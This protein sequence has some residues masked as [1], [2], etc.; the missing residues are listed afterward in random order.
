MA[1]SERLVE[2]L[3]AALHKLFAEHRDSYFIGEDLND[4]YGG[5]FKVGKGLSTKYP[6]RVLTTPLSENG[7]L[8]VAGGLAL[9]GNKVIVEMMFGDFTFLAFDQLCNFAAKSVTMYGTRRPLQ[10]IVRCPVGGRRGYGPTHSQ[11]IQKH[12]IGVPNLALYELT[13]F[14]DSADV[15]LKMLA[16][17]E[18]CVYFEDKTLYG[19]RRWVDGT[20]DVFEFGFDGERDE[21]GTAVPRGAAAGADC[22]VI[23]TGGTSPFALAAARKLLLE[24]EIVCH[25]LTPSRL[26]PIDLDPIESRLTSAGHIVV[27]EEGV[28]GGTWGAE[29][30][31]EIYRK[32]WSRLRDRIRLVHSKPSIIP[33]APHLER[34]V[35][36]QTETIYDAVRAAF[37]FSDN[38]AIA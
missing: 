34:Q 35:L 14:H 18:P 37:A 23:A 20:D 16:R 12:L 28:A 10:L 29:V 7:F 22:V 1:R 17:K 27:V 11:S 31:N 5:A 3:N 36:V 9:C 26:Y 32:Y 19:S 2:N 21:Y 8:G 13:P 15:F 33:T 4:P 24:L 6:E 25:V 30:A 38:T